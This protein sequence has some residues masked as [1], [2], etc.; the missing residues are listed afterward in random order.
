MWLQNSIKFR[1]KHQREEKIDPDPTLKNE[2][3]AWIHP[4]FQPNRMESDSTPM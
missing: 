4:R 3:M 2:N 1:L